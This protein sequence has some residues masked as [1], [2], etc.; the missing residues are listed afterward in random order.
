MIE[1]SDLTQFYYKKSRLQQ[2]KGFCYT[3]QEKSVTKASER[4][5]LGVA[6]VTIQIKSLEEDLN[7]ELFKRVKNKLIPTEKGD[8]FY[9]MA[10]PIIQSTDGLF[11]KFLI[12]ASEIENNRIRIGSYHVVF[13]YILPKKIKQLLSSFPKTKFLFKSV[14][15]SLAY[16]EL[17][18]NNLDIVIYPIEENEKIPFEFKSIG[19]FEY[20]LVLVLNKKHPLAKKPAKQITKK[21]IGSSN[22]F[23][24]TKTITTGNP[25]VN[26]SKK[27]D[28]G[29]PW[30]AFS[31]KYNIQVN[32]EFENGAWGMVK[33]AIKENIG[34]GIM[35][36]NFINKSDK[37]LIIKPI[38]HLFSNPKFKIIIR[39]SGYITKSTEELIRLLK[40]DYSLSDAN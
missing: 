21:D 22:L 4:M 26:F 15:K 30:M 5:G 7:T 11:R 13:S 36:K 38:D 19:S 18:N 17:K 14:S 23:N 3:Y 34:I 12:E 35:S 24:L 20:D 40:L 25:W 29:N 9:K 28:V 31:K 39:K 16:E 37:N 1:P 2:L 6:T 27:Y 32:I 8:M 33:E 10:L